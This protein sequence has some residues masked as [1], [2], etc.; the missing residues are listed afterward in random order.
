MCLALPGVGPVW[1][2]TEPVR[3][4]PFVNDYA[5]LIDAPD[6]A[7][8]RAGLKA[9][10]DETGIEATVLTVPDR[11][12][13]AP[14]DSVEAFARAVFNAWGVGRKDRND[15][16][17]LLVAPGDRAARIALGAAYDQGYDTLASDIVSQTLAPALRDGRGSEG[18]AAA[19]LAM[20]DRIGRRHAEEA[21]IMQDAAGRPKGRDTVIILLFAAAT[22]AMV[23]AAW[24]RRRAGTEGRAPFPRATSAMSD[25]PT[26]D[27]DRHA[28][29][30]PG[31][32][33]ERGEGG[34][35]RSDGGGATGRW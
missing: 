17:L 18:I 6:E 22:G 35:G 21:G 16:L 15:G 24:R 32:M 30:A 10:L 9:L 20:A 7:R 33:A 28:G 26:Q 2:E 8:I 4:D 14:S 29:A 19:A 34:G 12:A 13:F 11:A 27:P 1:A 5:D 25:R 3:S 31:S 23:I